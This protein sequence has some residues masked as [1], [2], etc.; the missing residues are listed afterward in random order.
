MIGLS[1]PTSEEIGDWDIPSALADGTPAAG[2]S[3]PGATDTA[4]RRARTRTKNEERKTNVG[5][6]DVRGL[7]TGPF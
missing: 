5:R 6:T 3:W 4:A 7:F 2:P 1:T